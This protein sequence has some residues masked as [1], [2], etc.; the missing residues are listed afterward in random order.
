MVIEAREETSQNHW[1]FYNRISGK[2]NNRAQENA[3]TWQTILIKLSLDS[4]TNIIITIDR[5]VCLTSGNIFILTLAR[6]FKFIAPVRS[7]YAENNPF[8]SLNYIT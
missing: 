1:F 2:L 8:M 4:I 6:F 7:Q 5:Y 3:Y